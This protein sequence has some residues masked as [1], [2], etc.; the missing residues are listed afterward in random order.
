[1]NTYDLRTLKDNSFEIPTGELRRYTIP[2]KTENNATYEL[3]GGKAATNG[4]D[5]HCI[6]PSLQG[7]KHRYVYALG[8]QGKGVWWNSIM[9]IDTLTGET[10]EW[11]KKGHFPGEPNFVPR[12]GAVDEDD[13]V[14]L[15]QI[16]GGD[17][18]TSY[19]LILDAKTWEPLA[20][21]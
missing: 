1:M 9:K 10:Q 6:H 4:I 7:K 20:K 15:S 11:Y 13:G 17:E 2:L 16:L 19:L 12:P 8:N 21:A 18:G 5:L 14:L 3:I